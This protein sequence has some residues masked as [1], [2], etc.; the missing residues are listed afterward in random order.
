MS[1]AWSLDA[2]PP[3]SVVNDP[4]EDSTANS[5]INSC[6]SISA[7][8]AAALATTFISGATATAAASSITT[9]NGI[10]N[11]VKQPETNL[12]VFDNEQVS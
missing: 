5:R 8:A 10:I 11:N 6:N 7:T 9:G 12:I 4:L 3:E 1:E 2:D